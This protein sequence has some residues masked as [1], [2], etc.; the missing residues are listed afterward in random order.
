MLNYKL[1]LDDLRMSAKEGWIVARS[2]NDAV[3]VIRT[4]GIPR[5]ITFDHDLGD[6]KTGYDLAK[7]IIEYDMLHND[8]DDTFDFSVHSANP[9][10]AK[11]IESILN[12]YIKFKNDKTVNS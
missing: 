10:G 1:F 2:Y 3:T 12:N 4:L 8:I 11:N 5:T 9:I 6:E 7:F